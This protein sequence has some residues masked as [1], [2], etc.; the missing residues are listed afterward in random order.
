MHM[1]GCALGWVSWSAALLIWTS[2][3]DQDFWDCIFSCLQLP[4][5]EKSIHDRD[6]IIGKEYTIF[7][8]M[9]KILSLCGQRSQLASAMFC[10]FSTPPS[11]SSSTACSA[12]D[13]ERNARSCSK[14]STQIHRLKPCIKCPQLGAK[15]YF[16]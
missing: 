2:L 3:R 6:M 16:Q 5:L 13:S 10:L 1:Q 15:M 11:T 9:A 12:P 8:A 7:S 4:F 14:S